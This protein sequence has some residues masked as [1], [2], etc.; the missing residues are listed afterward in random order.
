LGLLVVVLVLYCMMTRG[1][2]Y[3]SIVV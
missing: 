2:G 1:D 3:L